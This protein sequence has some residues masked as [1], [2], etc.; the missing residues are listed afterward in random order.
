[1][2]VQATDSSRRPGGCSVH[3]ALIVTQVIFG[4]G[5]VVGKFGIQGANPLLFALIR[6]GVAGPILWLLSF[7]RSGELGPR[8]ADWLRFVG[9]GLALYSNQLCFLLGLK[10]CDPVF[11]SA[12]QPS[13]PIFTVVLVI[14]L[15]YEQPSLRKLLGILF[16]VAG[17]TAM[18]IL[19]SSASAGGDQNS[20]ALV[21][22]G[23]LLFFVNCLGTSCY[24]VFAKPLFARYAAISVTAWSYMVA[25][26]MMLVTVTIFNETPALLAFVCSSPHEITKQS[27]IDQAWIVPASMF[28]PLCYWV[29]L[30][31]IAAYALMTWGNK[32]AN[33][34]AVSAY[35]VLQP[36]T[37]ALISFILIIVKGTAWGEVYGLQKPGLQDI[38]IIGIIIGLGLLFSEPTLQKDEQPVD[39]LLLGTTEIG[40]TPGRV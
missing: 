30:Q 40:S 36:F 39:T 8:R 14:I 21:L 9:T 27:C 31:S 16:A 33:A 12:W 10:F 7:L 23:N 19:G 38:G 35:T 13:Q 28:L 6:E 3:G 5:A 4:G 11:G 15:G 34:S 1:M 37:S 32:Y 24:I 29:F 22:T 25:A 2:V 26:S 18:V 20:T 17:A